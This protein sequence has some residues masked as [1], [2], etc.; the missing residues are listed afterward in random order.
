MRSATVFAM[1]RRAMLYC[2]A[3]EPWAL[4]NYYLS[5][6]L[7]NTVYA[8]I[9]DEDGRALPAFGPIYLGDIFQ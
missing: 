9:T 1:C 2:Y 8:N 5:Y 7:S 4:K 3:M 6:M